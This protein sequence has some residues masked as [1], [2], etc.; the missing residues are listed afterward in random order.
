M[1][2]LVRPDITATSFATVGSDPVTIRLSQPGAPNANLEG[3]AGNATMEV[4]NYTTRIAK[5]V[6]TEVIS[7]YLFLDKHFQRTSDAKPHDAAAGNAISQFMDAHSWQFSL[8]IF[9]AG[10]IAVPLYYF[11]SS[12]KGQS[13]FI[14]VL[15]ASIAYIIWTYATQGS[16]Y[17]IDSHTNYY[18]EW[19]SGALVVGYT[20]LAGLVKPGQK[21]LSD[22]KPQFMKAKPV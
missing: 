21:N 19:L 14:N 11:A 12:D 5:Y 7:L 10:L 13:I 6:P 17:Y 16:V 9:L 1:S 8:G 22:L 2:R 4:D 15:L 20:F 3:V 18:D